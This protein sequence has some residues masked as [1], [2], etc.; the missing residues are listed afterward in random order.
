MVRCVLPILKKRQVVAP[1][2]ND[3]ARPLLRKIF[4]KK[5]NADCTILQLY[6]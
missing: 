4:W 6:V 1:V 2:N 5:K 3:L